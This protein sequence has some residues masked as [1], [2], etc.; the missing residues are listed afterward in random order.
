[1][2][3]IRDYFQFKPAGG[4][5]SDLQTPV[6]IVDLQIVQRNVRRW[7]EQCDRLG[8]ANRPHIK[9]HKLVPLAKYQ[10]DCG[11]QGIT[12]Q[13]LDEAEV[14]ADGGVSNMLLTFNIVGRPKLARLAALAAR[15][16]IS[17]VA[18]SAEV[19]AGLGQVGEMA[20]RSI[21][22]LVECDT[23]GRRNGVQTPE[24]AV[25]LGALIDKTPG[26]QFGGLM[27]YPATHL[28]RET[29]A[30]L[31]EA[32][33]LLSRSQLDISTVSSGGSLDMWSEEGL[34][35]ITEYRAGTYIYG[36]R[37]L[38]EGG[39]MA[40]DECALTVL[41]TVVSRPVTDRAILDAGT[42]AL[43]SDLLGLQGYGTVRELGEATVYDLNEEHGFVDVSSSIHKPA[44]GDLLRILPNHVCPVSNLFDQVICMWGN[45]LLG[46]V[47]VD[48]RGGVQ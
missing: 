16:Q 11:A 23:G 31:Q 34:A 22:V 20:G 27:T 42:K 6:P 7:Q 18:D 13:K 1:M 41:S 26:V 30:F 12:V 47:A 9:T 10:L 45:E 15:T 39:A 40:A 37:Y 35:P 32:R 29:A 19:V 38:V 36:D 5:V 4:H 28:R 24:E 3:D 21:T 14:M 48:A 43:T 33:D 17:V 46:A 44:V 25:R 2:N 8:I